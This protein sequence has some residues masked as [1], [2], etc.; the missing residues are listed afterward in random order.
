MKTKRLDQTAE[1]IE[2][3]SDFGSYRVFERARK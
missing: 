3:Q 2:E 1:R